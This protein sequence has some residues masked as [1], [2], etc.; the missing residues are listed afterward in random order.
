MTLPVHLE[1]APVVSVPLSD[2]PWSTRLVWFLSGMVAWV[3]VVLSAWLQPDPRGFGTHQ[4]L[5]LPPCNFQELTHVP[6]PGCGL[7][8][9]FARMAHGHA[10]DALRAHL[11]GPPLFLMTLVVA[12][13]APWAVRRAFPVGRVLEHPATSAALGTTLACG[14][15]TWGWRFFHG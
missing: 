15:A 7:T 14:L 11:M 8:T 6:C 9:S 12:L 10:L 2:T 5:G 3:V 1:P 4:Q 13:L